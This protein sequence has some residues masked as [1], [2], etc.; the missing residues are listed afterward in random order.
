MTPET[1]A[2]RK[3]LLTLVGRLY[4][5]DPDTFAPETREVMERWRPA[6]EEMLRAA[7]EGVSNCN[8]T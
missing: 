2:L 1:Q 4:D 5:E 6:F 7:G 8:A 3:D